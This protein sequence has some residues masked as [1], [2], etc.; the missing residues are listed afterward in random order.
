MRHSVYRCFV[1]LTFLVVSCSDSSDESSISGTGDDQLRHPVIVS[2]SGFNSCAAVNGTTTPE[3]T[4]RW[5]RV[6]SLTS[7]YS[8]GKKFW[9]KSCFDKWG[10][11]HFK[12]SLDPLI[13]SRATKDNFQNI[14]AAIVTLSDHGKHPVFMTGHSYGAW[15]AL[16][17]AA[18]LP[19]SITIPAI[20]TID[21]ISPNYCSAANYLQ[22]ILSPVSV[23]PAL[24]G[25]RQAPPEFNSAARRIILDRLPD[26]AWRH[27]YQRN[28]LPLASSAF[29]GGAQ[30]HSAMD[31]SPFLS[32][33]P[34]GARPS[35][36]AHSG[37]DELYSI[38]YSFEVTIQSLNSLN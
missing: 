24:S 4:D 6:A 5:D 17:L 32:Q 26:R 22:A 23:G 10:T 35:F 15:L 29:L 21:P 33:F 25:C 2:F 30:P 14:Y 13:V 19:R 7:K 31:L 18:S 11:I 37:I 3:T 36:N 20:F 28:F 34:T 12:T 16:K 1:A 27:Y 8:N 9:L 38:W